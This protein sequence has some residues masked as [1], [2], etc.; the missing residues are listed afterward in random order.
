MRCCFRSSKQWRF[1]ILQTFGVQVVV[2]YNYQSTLNKHLQRVPKDSWFIFYEQQFVSIKLTTSIPVI[3]AWQLTGTDGISNWHVREPH[4]VHWI[5]QVIGDFISKPT[6]FFMRKLNAMSN[7]WDINL[8][9]FTNFI[10]FTIFKI[11]YNFIYI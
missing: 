1:V 5:A 2:V 7:P 3:S 8:R 9:E 6:N 10:S 4:L 11:Y